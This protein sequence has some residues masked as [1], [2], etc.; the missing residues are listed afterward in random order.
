MLSI[1]KQ[2]DRQTTKSCIYTGSWSVF[3]THCTPEGTARPMDRRFH[4]K[5]WW[6]SW[7][8]AWHW[9]RGEVLSQKWYFL[10]ILRGCSWDVELHCPIKYCKQ[11]AIHQRFVLVLGADHQLEIKAELPRTLET[12]KHLFPPVV[13]Q[14][15]ISHLAAE[16]LEYEAYILKEI[17]EPPLFWW[18][19]VPNWTLLPQCVLNLLASLMSI[20]NAEKAFSMFPVINRKERAAVTNS[21]IG[22]WYCIYYNKL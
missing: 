4:H 12:Y 21:N 15:D 18:M 10:G 7:L 6:G 2:L 16:F 14:H 5:L 13:P 11:L 1:I 8:H 17:V 9:R 22:K 20:A 19:H 3:S